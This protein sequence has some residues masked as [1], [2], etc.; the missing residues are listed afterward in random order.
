MSGER[1]RRE[2]IAGLRA[3]L[4]NSGAGLRP[5]MNGRL[6]REITGARRPKGRRDARPTT[7]SRRAL[8]GHDRKASDV[9]FAKPSI[10][11]CAEEPLRGQLLSRNGVAP[12]WAPR[13][14]PRHI[15]EGSVQIAGGLQ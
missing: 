1:E 6:A 11:L 14:A 12:R 13:W 9:C 5:A 15:L 10:A 4:E 7:F 2:D 8:S 3:R